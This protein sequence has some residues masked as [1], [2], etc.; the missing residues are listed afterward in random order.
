MSTLISNQKKTRYCPKKTTAKQTEEEDFTGK[1]MGKERK[2]EEKK[3]QEFCGNI[4]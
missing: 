3:K 2:K 1:L 4:S